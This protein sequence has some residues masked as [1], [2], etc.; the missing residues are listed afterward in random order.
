MSTYRPFKRGD[1][2]VRGWWPIRQRGVVITG[3]DHT[4][5][6]RVLL[7]CPFFRTTEEQNGHRALKRWRLKQAVA[8]VWPEAQGA[9]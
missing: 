5:H 8:H 3:E 4:G 1:V 7:W 9:G 6:F 2:V